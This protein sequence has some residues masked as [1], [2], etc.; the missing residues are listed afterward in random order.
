M[1]V[2]LSGGGLGSGCGHLLRRCAGD[3]RMRRAGG[4]K[5]GLRLRLLLADLRLTE[6]KTSEA[7]VLLT[8]KMAAVESA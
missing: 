7:C 2:G 8:V 5:A 6:V 1:C 3:S 4:V